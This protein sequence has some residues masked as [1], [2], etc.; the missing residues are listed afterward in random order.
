MPKEKQVI[1]FDPTTK[2]RSSLPGAGDDAVDT[3]IQEFQAEL[4]HRATN[5]Q[6]GDTEAVMA[7]PDGGT[8]EGDDDA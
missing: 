5:G 4:E 8:S 2:V 7:E 1:D 3:D 6:D